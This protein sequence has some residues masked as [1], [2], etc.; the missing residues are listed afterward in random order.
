[1]GR[2]P[3][4]SASW[5]PL[6]PVPLGTGRDSSQNSSRCRGVWASACRSL[7]HLPGCQK[8]PPSVAVRRKCDL[9]NVI[10]FR[11]LLPLP[12]S[13]PL[14]IEAP[15]NHTCARRG[16]PGGL[17]RS[18]LS[19]PPP[20]PPLETKKARFCPLRRDPYTVLSYFSSSAIPSV[21]YPRHAWKG[22]VKGDLLRKKG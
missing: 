13:Q 21:V 19:P 7:R 8:P 16:G 18:G 12:P 4:F 15:P 14:V 17:Q 6:Q 2:L 5:Y 3:F 10:H 22:K 11:L 9:W 1:M 20:T